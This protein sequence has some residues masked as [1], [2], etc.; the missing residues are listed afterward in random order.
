MHPQPLNVVVI[1]NNNTGTSGMGSCY[2]N[3]GFWRNQ[4]T[5]SH[6]IISLT[7][8]CEPRSTTRTN[9]AD[10]C[11]KSIKPPFIYNRESHQDQRRWRE[12]TKWH[13]THKFGDEEHF[14]NGGEGL[15]ASGQKFYR[16]S[17]CHSPNIRCDFSPGMTKV[18]FLRCVLKAAFFTHTPPI[19][20]PNLPP[21]L[22]STTHSSTKDNQFGQCWVCLC[23]MMSIL[24]V[25]ER[26]CLCLCLC[27][28]A[29]FHLFQWTQ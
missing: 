27:V 7:D 5:S 19:L 4:Q 10:K 15:A 14:R 22:H 9:W 13:G 28:C 12:T 2:A 24:C 1:N 17:G 20:L 6:S 26:A 23:S 11:G 3:L 8:C 16:V 29:L 18:T 25:C 21:S